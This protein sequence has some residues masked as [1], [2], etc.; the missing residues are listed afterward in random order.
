LGENLKHKPKRKGNTLEV[1]AFELLMKLRMSMVYKLVV[2][3]LDMALYHTF[4]LFQL[5]VLVLDMA[6]YHTFLLFQLDVLVLDMALYHTFL[7]LQ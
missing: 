4:L 1:V 7:L 2:L 5:D 6:L 3:V